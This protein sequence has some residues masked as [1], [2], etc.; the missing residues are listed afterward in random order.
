MTIYEAYKQ[1]KDFVQKGMNIVEAKDLFRSNYDLQ[2]AY[3]FIEDTSDNRTE[4][5]AKK[6]CV[7]YNRKRTGFSLRSMSAYRSG[8]LKLEFNPFDNKGFGYKEFYWLTHAW[9]D[10]FHFVEN[11]ASSILNLA[12]R[13]S[14]QNEILSLNDCESPFNLSKDCYMEIMGVMNDV[15]KADDFLMG[16]YNYSKVNHLTKCYL[17][18]GADNLKKH[19]ETIAKS[20]SFLL[21]SI[22]AEILPST[23]GATVQWNQNITA[24]NSLSH[25]S[26]MVSFSKEELD[27]LYRYTKHRPTD[28]KMKQTVVESLQQPLSEKKNSNEVMDVRD[29]KQPRQAELTMRLGQSMAPE[30]LKNLI[31]KITALV[32]NLFYLKRLAES[33]SSLEDAY[34]ELIECYER[35]ISYADDMEN[36]IKGPAA[37]C[38]H[39]EVK[40][41]KESEIDNFA[42]T[43][44]EKNVKRDNELLG[45]LQYISDETWPY[46]MDIL[47]KLPAKDTEFRM[48]L[49]LL[50][51]QK[52]LIINLE[53]LVRKSTIT[54]NREPNEHE[55][56]K[57]IKKFKEFVKDPFK[58]DFVIE[59][60]HCL[61]GNKTNTD[62]IRVIRDA[63]W[64]GWLSKKPT[65]TSIK[66]EFPTITC[67]ATVISN[68]L[69][70]H[71][72]NEN[73]I[74]QI[75]R[76]YEVG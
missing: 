12:S 70:E 39:K 22:G 11:A 48:C 62:A 64:I 45:E 61:I 49:I 44:F 13:F 28:E 31:D 47:D 53:K 54:T 57:H 55:V 25:S 67:S 40:E 72:P 24:L 33:D 69:T 26:S 23:N 37:M 66:E 10:Y 5:K 4:L 58:T 19:Y 17:K 34:T 41:L 30:L 16:L 18:N 9:E 2:F 20:F 75:R 6:K 60:L 36:F 1:L 76:K 27:E 50:S 21:N 38:C 59:K 43:I 8:L 35:S 74:E 73:A 7:D 46:L 14:L 68:V 3:D 32:N 63:W 42:Y 51:Y 56:A 65:A 29:I 52:K 15:C 71:K